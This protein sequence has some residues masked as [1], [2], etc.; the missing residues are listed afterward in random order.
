MRYKLIVFDLDETLWTIQQLK[1]DPIRGPFELINS[2][3]AVGETASVTLFR[4]VRALLKNLEKRQKHVSLASRSDPAV[5]EE[6]LQLFDIAHYFSYEQ[7]GWQ[8]KS[9]AVLNILKAI[10][11]IEKESI[12]PQEVLFIDDYPTNVETVKSTGAATLLFGRDIRSIQE[13]AF[14]LQ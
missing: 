12:A 2:H 10:R 13:L 9:T 14:I 11:D 3:E 7:Y 1:L 4:G 8:E 5:C 6:L